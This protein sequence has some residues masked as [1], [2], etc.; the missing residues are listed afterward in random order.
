VRHAGVADAAA[1]R[2]IRLEALADTPEAFGSTYAETVTW[3]DERWE[4]VAG[5]WNVYLA[6]L[7]GEVVGMASGGRHDEHPG[8][9]WL[10][11]M[12]LT[13]RARGSG[14]AAQLVDA[15]AQW[16]RAEGAADL[17]LSVT[18]Q[19]PR[20]RAF[21]E[22]VGFRPT[23]EVA[24]LHRDAAVALVTMVRRLDRGVV[25]LSVV[26]ADPARLEDL[27]R[28]VL[29]AGDAAAR[30]AD[31][32]D[33]DPATLHLAGLLGDRV[34]AS[35]S[36]YPST[37]PLDPARP[38]AQLRFMA[39]EPECQGRGYGAAVLRAAESILVGRGVREMWANAR[40]TA[41]GFYRA[42]GWRTLPGS[43]HVSAETRL[44][45]TVIV[46]SLD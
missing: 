42:T 23:G 6:E 36:F 46:K 13:A 30:I 32:R 17:Y 24:S 21:Y 12:Y 3:S 27:R 22:K 7:D 39:T 10:F 44:P 29:R 31:A 34:V 2:A 19:V 25:P 11:G 35:A 41:L 8:S 16:A 9:C 15:V 38:S 37:S 40:D 20:A 18:D 33:D 1:L 45:H 28:R 4:Q 26:E 14:L 43:E 5:E